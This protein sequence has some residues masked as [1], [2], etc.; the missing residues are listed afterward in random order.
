MIKIN[1]TFKTTK[2]LEKWLDKN[3]SKYKNEL[4]VNPKFGKIY[5]LV[6]YERDDKPF[7]DLVCFY[8]LNNKWCA[9]YVWNYHYEEISDEELLED[10]LEVYDEDYVKNK[11]TYY[12]GLRRKDRVYFFGDSYVVC[13]LLEKDRQLTVL[14][15]LWH[16]EAMDYLL[17]MQDDKYYDSIPWI[18]EAYSKLLYE[19]N[20][21]DDKS[22][23]KFIKKL[24]IIH[25]AIYYGANPKNNYFEKEWY[26][27][28]Y[29]HV[30]TIK[31]ISK[32][33]AKEVY[34]FA[35]H[36]LKDDEFEEKMKKQR[37]ERGYSDSDV[38]NFHYWFSEKISK[39]LKD[40]ADNHMGYPAEI[41]R[42]YFEENKKDL[43]TQ[44]Y[45]TWCSYTNDKKIKKQKDKA[46][47][48]CSKKWEDILN[49]MSFLASEL[50][51]D[52]C[53]MNEEKE[54]L[55]DEWYN[56]QH[57]FEEKYG[58]GGEKLKSAEELKEEKDKGHFV[59]YN[60]SHLPK[61]DKLRINSEAAWKKLYKYEKEMFKYQN[62][63]KDELFKLMN[64]YFWNLWD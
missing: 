41:D 36:K 13:D 28:E 32:E 57:E 17:Y 40:L 15:V 16:K 33:S 25:K 39:M 61:G 19:T 37:Y 64:K 50:N 1:K 49:R 43:Y 51:E 54:R 29:G 44:D 60:P 7:V 42:E 27:E 21:L 8:I 47:D 62:K 31:D 11:L 3:Y 48:I 35:L 20:S 56:Y 12:N 24:D 52:T 4:F 38:W 59:W 10:L 55:L 2:S 22:K 45:S 5:F 26:L 14:G 58:R 18:E 53:S 23:Q 30:N 46:S 34:E 9:D 6:Y 63:C